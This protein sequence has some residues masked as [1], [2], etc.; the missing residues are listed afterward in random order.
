MYV[1]RIIAYVLVLAGAL[2][3]GLVGMFD[4]DLIASIFGAMTIVT[5]TIY[6]LAGISAASLLLLNREMFSNTCSCTH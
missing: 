5:R 1:L 2:N 4:F 6:S 3:W